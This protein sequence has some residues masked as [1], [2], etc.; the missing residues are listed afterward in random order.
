M[1][2]CY[3]GDLTFAALRAM[4]E[5]LTIVPAPAR[6]IANLDFAWLTES[7]D[8]DPEFLKDFEQTIA[9]ARTVARGHA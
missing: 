5:L 9:T 7:N 1:V 6:A 2:T 3:R 4:P 8:F